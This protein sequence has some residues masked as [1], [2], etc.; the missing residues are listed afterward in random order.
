MVQGSA[1]PLLVACL[2]VLGIFGGAAFATNATTGNTLNSTATSNA[3]ANSASSQ[4]Q[5]S[6]YSPFIEVVLVVVIVA[7]II[8]FLMLGKPPSGGAYES[9]EPQVADQ[10]GEPS[11]NTNV[12]KPE[13]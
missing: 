2:L 13:Y 4:N 10:S 5:P 8:I 11:G 7:M 9:Q 1:A 3:T 6:P 12:P